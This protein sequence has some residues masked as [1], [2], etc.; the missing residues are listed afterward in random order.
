MNR[1]Y[2][3]SSFKLAFLVKM[4]EAK[5]TFESVLFRLLHMQWSLACL[6]VRLTMYM[7]V[8]SVL[9]LCTLC[10]IIPTSLEGRC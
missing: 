5:T 2:D 4:Y 9:C 7:Y 10:S 1:V 8:L 3:L 6:D